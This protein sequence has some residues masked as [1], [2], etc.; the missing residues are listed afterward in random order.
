MSEKGS[1]RFS[2]HDVS[3]L[4]VLDLAKALDQYPP[5][6]VIF[7]IQPKEISW[8]T[9]LSPEVQASVPKVME[10]VLEEVIR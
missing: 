1:P 4:E 2:A 3:L 6:V 9:E 10:T 8:G 5:E 7:G